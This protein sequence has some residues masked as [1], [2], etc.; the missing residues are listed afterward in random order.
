MRPNIS[1]QLVD[2]TLEDQKAAENKG[3]AKKFENVELALY[4]KVRKA[5]EAARPLL[6]PDEKIIIFFK[7]KDLVEQLAKYFTTDKFDVCFVTGDTGDEERVQRWKKFY[8]TVPIMLTNKAGYYGVDHPAV[9]F[10]L[11]AETP[12]TMIDFSQASGRL[13]RTGRLCT[14]VIFVWETR[15]KWDFNQSETFSGH[16]SM[17]K[18]IT[19]DI[20]LRIE[21]GLFLDG[22]MHPTCIQLLLRDDLDAHVGICS[23]CAGNMDQGETAEPELGDRLFCM[24][25][26]LLQLLYIY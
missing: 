14:C 20:C 1:Y 6:K 22:S 21:Q 3:F 19:S 23:I 24:Y 16:A 26:I 11:W 18:M 4:L 12:V 15:K 25:S 7:R 17:E 2:F 10:V 5:V 9:A 13:G 8:D